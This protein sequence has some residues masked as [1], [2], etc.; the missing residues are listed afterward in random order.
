MLAAF[1]PAI[2]GKGLLGKNLKDQSEELI[3]DDMV[4]VVN[5]GYQIGAFPAESDYARLAARGDISPVDMIYHPSRGY[6][7][8][9]WIGCHLK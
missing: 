8:G 1:L 9:C 3:P 2:L 6:P 5:A 7:G 4:E